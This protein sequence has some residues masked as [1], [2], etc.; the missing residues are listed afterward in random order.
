MRKGFV[1]HITRWIVAVVALAGLAAAGCWY[2]QPNL[3]EWYGKTS[4]GMSKDEIIKVLG[5]P[6]VVLGN[7]LFYL[8]DDPEAPARFRFVLNEKEFVVEKYVETK[9]ELAKKAEETM[10]VVPP[11]ER[12][13]GEEGRVYP[14]GPLPRFEKK[15]PQS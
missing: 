9:K 4:V 15:P 1:M 10:G 3:D 5:Q 6:S 14:G 13:P 2:H 11:V 7:E 8:Y 12:L